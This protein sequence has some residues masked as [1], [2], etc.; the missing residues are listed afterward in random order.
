MLRLDS[1]ALAALSE[2]M[3][4]TG[5]TRRDLSELF[6]D[7]GL[8]LL[9]KALVQ[10]G[11]E[12]VCID[13]AQLPG[14]SDLKLCVREGVAIEDAM[15]WLRCTQEE[16]VCMCEHWQVLEHLLCVMR[17]HAYVRHH[18]AECD[19]GKIPDMGGY[20]L[21]SGPSLTGL[22]MLSPGDVIEVQS[23]RQREGYWT[24]FDDAVRECELNHGPVAP[25]SLAHYLLRYPDRISREW[26]DMPWPSSLLCPGTVFVRHHDKDKRRCI[27]AVSF[28][29]NKRPNTRFV[30]LH[31]GM[32]GPMH[33]FLTFRKGL[34][35]S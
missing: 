14:R 6:S 23:A 24:S 31:D 7:R 33:H 4:R 32:V 27:P 35:K 19:L 2:N 21:V 13:S 3:Q 29:T 5:W 28:D 12:V 20:D 17:G 25:V 18:P 16:M 15:W 22:V 1:A 30:E 11:A 8:I 34:L 26:W 9:W 10:G